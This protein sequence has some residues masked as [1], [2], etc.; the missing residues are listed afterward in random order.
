MQHLIIKIL[1]FLAVNLD[2]RQFF[3]PGK[4]RATAPISSAQQGE[5]CKKMSE[6]AEQNKKKSL[7]KA[8]TQV[9]IA[10]AYVRPVS[11]GRSA[12][13]CRASD[14]RDAFEC[15]CCEHHRVHHEEE[16]T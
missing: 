13:F 10:N 8:G 16:F 2:I 12:R 9:K 11:P 5:R 15:G 7:T 14:Q 4:G 1:D 6:K 3:W